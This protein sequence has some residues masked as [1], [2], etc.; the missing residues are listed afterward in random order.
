MRVIVINT[1]DASER[2]DFQR[3]QFSRLKLPFARLNAFTPGTVGDTFMGND[4]RG[5]CGPMTPGERAC[6]LSH[7][8]AWQSVRTSGGPAL[9]VEDDALLADVV[10]ELLLNVSTLNVA[11]HISLEARGRSKLL[12][13][14]RIPAAHGVSLRRLYVDWHGAAAYVLWPSGAELLLKRARRGAATVDWLIGT[15]FE[16]RSYQTDPACAVQLDM[17]AHYDLGLDVQTVSRTSVGARGLP[18]AAQVVRSAR[19][20]AGKGWRRLRYAAVAKS[21]TVKVLPERFTI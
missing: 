18:S 8:S 6:L 5:F 4:W 20:K 7:C 17:A 15:A 2:M 16:M 11:D 9:I 14:T 13:M 1:P 3:D 21:T 10:P 12:G 19:A